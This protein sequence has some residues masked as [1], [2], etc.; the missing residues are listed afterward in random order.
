[1]LNLMTIGELPTSYKISQTYNEQLTLLCR[2][3]ET[4]LIPSVDNN[5][6][7]VKEL[8]DYVILLKE[9]I[10]KNSEDISKNSLNINNI[11]D[12]VSKITQEVNE[13]IK[14]IQDILDNITTINKALEN[15]NQNLITETNTDIVNAIII[16]NALSIPAELKIFGNNFQKTRE[17][18]NIFNYIDNVKAEIGGLTSTVDSEGYITVNGTAENAYVNVV[19]PIDINDLLEDGQTYTLWQENYATEK[20][21]GLYL[22]LNTKNISSGYIDRKDA[23]VSK[24]TFTVNKS[25]YSYSANLQIGNI[26]TFS[27][28]KNRY[29]IYKGTDEKA[30]ELPGVSPSI[31]YPSEIEVVKNIDIV[32]SNNTDFNQYSLVAQQ[33]MLKEDYFIL[34]NGVWNEYH[35]YNKIES[36]NNEEIDTEFISTTGELSKGATVY[37]KVDPFYLACTEEESKILDRLYYLRLFKE[38]NNIMPLDDLTLLQLF[39]FKKGV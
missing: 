15:I 39:Y 28:Y 12:N 3:I 7:A 23:S 25:K 38:T 6:Y 5:A 37:Y 33:D 27:N 30:Y 20:Y 8:Q 31:G 13:N 36:Y 19:S 29:M 34:K 9:E 21:G 11:I 10:N 4:I 35:N 2:F 32:H 24:L 1:M 17:G 26:S 18:Y 16:N 22:Q 14:N